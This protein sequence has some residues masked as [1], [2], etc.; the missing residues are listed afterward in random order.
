MTTERLKGGPAHIAL[1]E[2]VSKAIVDAC[3]A[4]DLNLDE[5]LC[6]VCNVAADYARGELGDD[7]LESL[8]R[9]ILERAGDPLPPSEPAGAA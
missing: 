1:A 7:Y 8:A 5:A 3:W 4:D 9:V 6:V 2:K